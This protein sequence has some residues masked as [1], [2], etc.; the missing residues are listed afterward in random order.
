MSLLNAEWIG[1]R[2][3]FRLFD[4]EHP[5]QTVAHEADLETAAQRAGDEG[6]DGV[7]FISESAKVHIMPNDI[8]LHKP[9][10]ETWV[11]CG[12]N[13]TDG[14]LIACGYPF[15]SKAKVEDCELLEARYHVEPQSIEEINILKSHGL[16]NYIDV[17]SAIFHDLL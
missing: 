2:K 5:Q 7:D 8:V 4:A 1:H 14:T 6:Y 9:T 15:P 10:G 3:A 16:D 13:H 17:R 11:V 12:V